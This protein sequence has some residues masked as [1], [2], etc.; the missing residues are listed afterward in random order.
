LR[1]RARRSL[2]KEEKLAALISSL[3]RD[4]QNYSDSVLILN[5]LADYFGREGAPERFVGI[6]IPLKRLDLPEKTPPRPD[7]LLQSWDDVTGF[8][9]E[10]K[11]SLKGDDLV[12]KK[13]ILST[14][15]YSQPRSGWKTQD[16]RVSK[17]ETFLIAPRDD[18]NR[19]KEIGHTD[20]EV[21][22]VL[23]RS[24]ALLSWD[25]SRTT[26]PER[27][28]VLKVG[29]AQSSMEQ[30]FAPPGLELGQS[31][32]TDTL[33]KVLFYAAEPPLPYSMEKIYL[34]ANAIKAFET[35]KDV[36]IMARIRHYYKE[37]IL[38]TA[39]ELYTEQASFFLP[40]ERADQQIPQV[41]QNWIQKALVGL[42]RIKLA[43]PVIPIQ[44][45]NGARPVFLRVTRPG[46][47]TDPSQ[48]FFIPSRSRGF[49]LRYHIVSSYARYKL[50]MEER[51]SG[52]MSN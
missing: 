52:G 50:H 23:Q 19:L 30:I 32:L 24:L 44:P 16:G 7:L 13:E 26:G 14:T 40:W 34:F 8:C 38:V 12:L 9:L 4:Y 11:W 6:N 25:F 41:R 17:V 18:C 3:D 33:A 37:G 22:Q 28:Y 36:E 47:E 42:A 5:G 49:E 21:G 10:L 15:R 45:L 51:L 31:T 29:G 1:A 39:R 35:L 20:N 27:L 48:H 46:W 43:I 2:G